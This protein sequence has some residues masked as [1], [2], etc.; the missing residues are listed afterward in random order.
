MTWL[1]RLRGRVPDE[2]LE[3]PNF[4]EAEEV[5]REMRPIIDDLTNA[6]V[7]MERI[8]KEKQ[9]QNQFPVPP[10]TRMNRT[11]EGIAHGDV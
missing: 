6:V 5:I 7:R 9:N 8:L 10:G 1:D 3:D 11:R 2:D 4:Q